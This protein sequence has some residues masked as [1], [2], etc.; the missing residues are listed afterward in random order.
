MTGNVQIVSE[1]WKPEWADRAVPS[2]QACWLPPLSVP[3]TLLTTSPGPQPLQGPTCDDLGSSPWD[4]R[5]EFFWH[6][7]WVPLW[8]IRYTCPPTALPAPG[9]QPLLPSGPPDKPQDG[10]GRPLTLHPLADALSSPVAHPGRRNPHPCP[11]QAQKV[12]WALTTLL[13]GL[14]L[15]LPIVYPSWGAKGPLEPGP[16]TPKQL[17]QAHTSASQ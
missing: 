1:L 13:V 10:P 5:R 7:L 2:L 12:L 14:A 11:V 8:H 16:A 6:P 3:I 9:H 17:P 15:M 4:R